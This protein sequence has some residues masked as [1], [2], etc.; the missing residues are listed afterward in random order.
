MTRS[1]TLVEAERFFEQPELSHS[2]SLCLFDSLSLSLPLPVCLSLGL[3]VETW[4]GAGPPA[5]STF[6]GAF[7]G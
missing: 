3:A 6:S 2:L 5:S 4:V 1:H 7:I